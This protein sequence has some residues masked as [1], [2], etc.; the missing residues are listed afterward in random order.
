MIARLKEIIL[1][2]KS[3]GYTNFTDFREMIK[4]DVRDLKDLSEIHRKLDELL[5]IKE[6]YKDMLDWMVQMSEKRLGKDS[7][8]IPN[9]P[10]GSVEPSAF[11]PRVTQLLDAVKQRGE[12][13]APQAS[14]ATGLSSNRCTE[15]LN[16]LHR[17]NHVEKVRVGHEV[18]Y[19][20]KQ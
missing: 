20:L 3:R 9:V 15:L 16:L 4:D 7:G 8:N 19:R 17:T 5:E 6:L 13:S 14:E 1:G 2:K 12:L 11:S 10:E 18:F